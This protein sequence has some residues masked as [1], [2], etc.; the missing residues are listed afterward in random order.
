MDGG[1]GGVR[2]EQTGRKRWRN[3]RGRGGGGEWRDVWVV[4]SDKWHEMD[5]LL[6]ICNDSCSVYCTL[7]SLSGEDCGACAIRPE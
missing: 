1:S 4:I 2:G 5:G 6:V 3:N 7:L